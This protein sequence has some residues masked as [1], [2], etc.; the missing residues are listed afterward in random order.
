M[1]LSDRL[2]KARL[3]LILDAPFFG[4]LAFKL[5][6][7]PDPSV[8]TSHVDGKTIRI[9][10]DYAAKLT[11]PQLNG[12]IIENILHCAQGHLWRKGARDLDRWNA[13]ADQTSWEIIS[14]LQQATDGRISMPPNGHC[15]PQYANLS[16]EEVYHLLEQEDSKGKQQGQPPPQGYQ[17]PGSFD[18]PAPDAPPDNNDSPNN[19]PGDGDGD[20][21]GGDS[22]PSPQPPPPE[23]L[24]D[25]WKEAVVTAA[26]TERQRQQGNLPAWMKHLIEELV[27]P[28]V[29]WTEYVREFCHRLTRDDYSFRRPNRRFL[30]RGFILPSLQSESL[31]PIIGAFD[32]SGSIFCHPQLVQA[33]LS[34]FQG[35]LDLCRPEKMLL[36]DCDTQVHQ[37]KEYFPGDSLLEFVPQ[38][39]GGTDFRPIFRA[40]EQLPEPPACLIF[41]TDLWGT[42]PDTP[43]DFPVL[44]ANFGDPTEKAPFGTT[45]HVPIDQ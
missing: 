32:T 21:P 18:Q 14:K 37:T 42:F 24:E 10:P 31:G 4:T 13:A 30:Q 34:E 25:E 17:S 12:Q 40:A 45:I 9:N 36:I 3:N 39:G 29:P 8:P 43:P 15:K 2:S 28:K 7:Q 26:T 23:S 19:Q 33:I 20:S 27:E 41:L 44:W 35:V 38:G 6:V 16:T 5:K 11:E 1:N 22:A